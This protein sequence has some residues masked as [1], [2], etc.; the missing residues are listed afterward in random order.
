MGVKFIRNT[1]ICYNVVQPTFPDAC[2]VSA[3]RILVSFRRISRVLLRSAVKYGLLRFFFVLGVKFS[4]PICSLT[5]STILYVVSARPWETTGV[6]IISCICTTWRKNDHNATLW[7]N[8]QY[9]ALAGLN[10]RYYVKQRVSHIKKF[11]TTRNNKLKG[12]WARRAWEWK[13]TGHEGGLEI[14]QSTTDT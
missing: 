8:I 1:A 5:P 6:E 7:H 13:D 4:M 9:I 3:L 10:S 2:K 12:K 14:T 11:C